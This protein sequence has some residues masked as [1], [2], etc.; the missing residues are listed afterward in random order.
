MVVKTN[1]V[2]DDAAGMLQEF[3]PVPIGALLLQRPDDAF[4]HAVLLRAM[5]RDEPL[6]QA[7]A[8]H[9]RRIAAARE[10]QAVI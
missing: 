10:H 8:T 7:V 2:A 6:A 3:K 1:P 9:Q 4:N 5:R